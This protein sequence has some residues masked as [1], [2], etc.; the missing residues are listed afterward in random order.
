MRGI[1][2]KVRYFA[3]EGDVSGLRYVSG[4]EISLPA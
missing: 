4:V 2:T 3:Q 1:A